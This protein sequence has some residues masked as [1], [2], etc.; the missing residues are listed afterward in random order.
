MGG[1]TTLQASFPG[2]AASTPYQ[3]I[4]KNSDGKTSRHFATP[5]ENARLGLEE[6]PPDVECDDDKHVEAMVDSPDQIEQLGAGEESPKD[7]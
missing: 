7:V 1:R 6:G 2:R 5:L 3:Y 4:Y